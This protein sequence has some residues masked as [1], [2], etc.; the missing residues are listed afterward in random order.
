MEGSLNT[1]GHHAAQS[2]AKGAVVHH[3]NLHM[4]LSHFPRRALRAAATGLVSAAALLSPGLHAQTNA[5]FNVTLTLSGSC[6]IAA[7]PILAFGTYTAGRTTEL[8]ASTTASL[9]CTEGVTFTPALVTG[10]TVTSTTKVVTDAETNLAYTLAIGGATGVRTATA[11]ANSVT[12]NGTMASGQ[13]GC[14]TTA[15]AGATSNRTHTLRL[16]Y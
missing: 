1:E 5:D 12:I 15:C 13:Y 16:T 3:W 4:P 8:T 11:G 6:T 2:T 9:T 14:V 7:I 10:P